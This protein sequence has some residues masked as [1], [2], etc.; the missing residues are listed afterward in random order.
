MALFREADIQG[1]IDQPIMLIRKQLLRALYARAEMPQVRGG[2][3]R[4]LKRAAEL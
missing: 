3:G 1:Y 2:P 4:G